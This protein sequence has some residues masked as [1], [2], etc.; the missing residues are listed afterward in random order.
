MGKQVRSIS[1]NLSYL[2]YGWH[3]GSLGGYAFTRVMASCLCSGDG[4]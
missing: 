3:L 1:L 2:R 4:G